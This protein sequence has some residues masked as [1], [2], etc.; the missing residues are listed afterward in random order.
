MN[1]STL[2]IKNMVCN[3]CI[4]VVKENLEAAGLQVLSTKLGEAIVAQGPDE[5]DYTQVSS[6]LEQDGFE[7]LDDKK[8]KLI[9][10]VKTIVIELI[11]QS[12]DIMLQHNFS[13]YIEE[14]AGTDYHYLSSLFSSTEGV[15]IE[16]YIILQRIERAKELMIYDELNLSEISYKLGYSSLQHFSNQFKK[17]TGYTPSAFKKLQSKPRKPLDSIR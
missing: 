4:K 6:L 11:H 2:Y 14:R 5:I 1:S 7:L 17:V 12:E 10:K 3:R 16:K 8:A 15:T 13:S 9:E